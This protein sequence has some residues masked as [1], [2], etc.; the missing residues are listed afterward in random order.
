MDQTKPLPVLQGRTLVEVFCNSFPELEDSGYFL[1]VDI[2]EIF[3][4]LIG[5][6][7]DVNL[8]DLLEESC[9]N[10]VNSYVN[11]IDFCS[12]LEV[13]IQKSEELEFYEICHNA[14]IILDESI[15]ILKRIDEFYKEKLIDE[16]CNSNGNM[17]EA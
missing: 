3:L 13:V 11:L 17:E 14:K 8:F 9:K 12:F 5:G 4:Y 7:V 15:L 6:K 2:D 1:F 16:D 10:D